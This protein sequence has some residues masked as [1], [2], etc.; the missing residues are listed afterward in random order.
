LGKRGIDY[1]TY[2]DWRLLDRLEIERV[3]R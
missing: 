2:D 3:R 1:V